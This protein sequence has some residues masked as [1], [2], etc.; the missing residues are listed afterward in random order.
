VQ[1]FDR[2]NLV[3]RHR[4]VYKFRMEPTP[5]EADELERIADVARFIHNWGLERRHF[6]A[7]T[8]Q[9]LV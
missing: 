6:A 8:K 2:V 5:L 1:S 4:K 9:Q 7:A 3:R